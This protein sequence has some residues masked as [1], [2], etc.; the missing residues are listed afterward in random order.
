MKL[1]GYDFKN[2]GLTY[3]DIGF[4]RI[5][6]CWQMTFSYQPDRGTYSFNIFAS[7]GTFNFLKL[8][9]RKDIYDPRDDL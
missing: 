3:P 8:P 7:Q 9:Y 5:L 2:K 1:F 6:H 4:S